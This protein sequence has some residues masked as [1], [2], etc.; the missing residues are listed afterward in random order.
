VKVSDQ[1]PPRL[2]KLPAIGGTSGAVRATADRRGNCP[3]VYSVGIIDDQPI[4]RAGMERL[5]DDH[6]QFDLVASVSSPAEFDAATEGRA[7]DVVILAV[8]W[9]ND[10]AEAE[11]VA[12]L[13]KITNP[14][15][16]S[17]WDRPMALA[18]AFRAGA[19]GCVTRHSG[20]QE[21]LTALRVVATGGLYVCAALVGQFQSEIGRGPRQDTVGLAPREIETIRWIALGFTQAQIATR[22]GLSQATVNTYAKRIRSKLRVTNKAELTRMAIRLGYLSEEQSGLDKG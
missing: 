17:T 4:A 14:L 21:M 3:T 19:R 7:C 6:P 16:T 8:P 1:L 5:I 20:H 18:Q 2:N 13:S 10:R 12:R 15:V 9:R 22:M 11:S